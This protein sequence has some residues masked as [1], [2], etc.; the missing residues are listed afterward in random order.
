MRTWNYCRGKHRGNTWANCRNCSRGAPSPR[1]RENLAST[2]RGGYRLTNHHGRGIRF[3]HLRTRAETRHDCGQRS[4]DDC[5]LGP[6]ANDIVELDHVFGA[7]P[8]ASITHRKPDISLFRRS[9]NVDIATKCVCILELASSQPQDARHDGIAAGGIRLHNF[10]GAP[11]IFENG[12]WRNTISKFLRNFQFTERGTTAPRPIA[13]TILRS[14]D[15][16]SGH[17][18]ATIK[19]GESLVFHAD[20][21]VML[22]IYSGRAGGKNAC[23]YRGQATAKKL[24]HS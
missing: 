6:I 20:Y 17:E 4:I 19:Q 9:V 13:Q 2:E 8:H 15:R 10:T 1:S 7:H 11:T 3:R 14:R 22:Q 21:D 23:D 5:D 24:C 12:A 18:R 16:I